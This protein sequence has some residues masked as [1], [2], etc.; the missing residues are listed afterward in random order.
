MTFFGLMRVMGACGGAVMGWRLGQ[1][2]AGLAGGI[3]GGFLGLV[4]GEWLGRIP[5]FLAHRQFSK[6]LSQATVAE[7]EQRLVEQCFISHLILGELHRMGVDL[8]PYEPLLL[9]WIHSDSPMH[10]QFGRA[11]LQ[12]FFPQRTATLK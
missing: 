9:E 1:H 8:A 3:V 11:S 5:T 12:L 2:V 10:Q 6:E 7:L 4:V